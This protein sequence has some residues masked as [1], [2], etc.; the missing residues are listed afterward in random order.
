MSKLLRLGRTIIPAAAVLSLGACDPT[1]PDTRDQLRSQLRTHE[2]EWAENGASSYS[3]RIERHCLCT[4][5]YDV[6][7]QIVNDE[8]VSGVHVF[9][10][11]ALTDEELAEQL[12]L[13][14]LFDIVEDALDR[15][16][17]GVSVSYYPEVGFVEHLYVNYDGGATN[18]DVEFLVSEYAPGAVP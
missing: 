6:T 2:E 16:V 11:D 14:D 15:R 9:S 12:A 18:D 4:D 8:I 1:G 3:V 7:L 10:G 17:P 13:P 5:P